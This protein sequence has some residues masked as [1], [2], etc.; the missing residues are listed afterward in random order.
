MNLS[1]RHILAALGAG[2]LAGLGLRSPLVL[3]EGASYPKRVVF[4]VTPHGHVPK[5]WKMT[6]DGGTNALATRDLTA[7]ARADMS[8]VLRPL[9]GFRERMLVIEGLSRTSALHDIAEI[10]RTSGDL[11]NHSVGVAHVL[12]G[13]RALQQAGSPCTGGARSIDQEL[14]MRLAGPGRFNS[15]V[16]G[17]GYIP[18]A[19][20]APF[21]FIG[22]GQ[23]T[24]VVASPEVAL[25][26][27]LGYVRAP[28]MTGTE[29]TREER[30][31]SLRSTVLNTV[32]REYEL[33]APKL[34]AEGK[35]KLLAHRELA[36][37][38]EASLGTGPS[39]KCDTNFQKSGAAAA[40]FA[41]LTKLAFA[42]DLTRV[43]TFVPA[44]P[45]TS[46]L[47]YA[48]S[49]TVHIYAHQSVEGATSC[50]QT[51]S[52]KAER[53]IVDL[54][55]WYANQLA[56]FLS[57]LDSVAEGNGTLLDNTLVVWLPELATPTHEH[58]DAFALL[59]GA[60]DFFKLGRYVKY[61][62][63]QVSPLPSV[64]L[65]G[66]AHNRLLTSILQSFGGQDKSFGLTEA[67]ASDGST[68]A[69]IGALTELHKGS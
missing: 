68:I 6:L 54:G 38:L 63:T 28:S 34:D 21:S 32:S 4:F 55:V 8:E 51:F 19:T 62:K 18:N 2:T 16:Y 3:A 22:R 29:P 47:G 23:A 15:R 61:E 20:V 53:A 24:P 59:A 58:H 35:R 11:N 30:I 7:V 67:R 52:K 40:Q 14:A 31:A 1:R 49:D 10:A 50:G 17:F 69:L 46:E 56:T 33:L 37:Q 48:A 25:S 39:A 27:L 66:P 12:T 41:R 43:V 57:E 44:V 9:H 42:C 64:P 13:T 26:D 5:G 36:M 60:S 45:E 65:L